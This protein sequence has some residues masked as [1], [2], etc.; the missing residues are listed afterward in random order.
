MIRYLCDDYSQDIF[1][2]RLKYANFSMGFV[3]TVFVVFSLAAGT[4]GPGTLFVIH[5]TNLSIDLLDPETLLF[6]TEPGLFV[7]LDCEPVVFSVRGLRHFTPRFK[8]VGVAIGD[9]RTE[10]HFRAALSA[11]TRLETTLLTDSIAAKARS[12]HQANE[13][14]VLLAALMGDIDAAEAAMT[15]L[16]HQRRVGLSVVRPSGDQ[17]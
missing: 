12:T 7:T 8:E 6:D 4:L 3:Q 9:I 11:W 1:G 2:R 10:A 17:R 15:R 5:M 16:E 13:H 14:Q